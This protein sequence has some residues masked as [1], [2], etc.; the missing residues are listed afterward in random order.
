MNLL[1]KEGFLKQQV[2]DLKLNEDF[3]FHLS[4]YKFSLNIFLC[5][6]S[7]LS[8]IYILS[9]STLFKSSQESTNVVS[10]RNFSSFE[11]SRYKFCRN[12]NYLNSLVI[13]NNLH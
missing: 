11:Y 10:L 3:N 2:D 7:S 12:L 5:C 4:S 9:N 6:L 1:C 13:S 8:L